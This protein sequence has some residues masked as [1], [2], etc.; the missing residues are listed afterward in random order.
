MLIVIA[1]MTVKTGKKAEIFALAQDLITATRAEE[2][3]L[4]YELLD[5]PYDGNSCVFVEK[6]T[7]KEALV[8]HLQTPHINDWRQKSE[9]LLAGKT[10]IELYQS[11][12]TTF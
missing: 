1:R 9:N 10:T 11:E 7:D 2:K 8:Q 12:E 6:W 4:S 3:C 5:D